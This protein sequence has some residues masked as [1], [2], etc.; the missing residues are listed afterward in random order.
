MMSLLMD[1][2]FE[3]E[4]HVAARR[5]AIVHDVEARGFITIAALVKHF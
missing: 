4:S 2:N 3:I 5:D 1:A